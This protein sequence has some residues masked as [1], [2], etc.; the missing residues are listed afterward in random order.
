[1]ENDKKQQ[2]SIEIKPEVANGTY[3][4][5]VI[6]GHSRSEF[7]LDFATRLPAMPKAMV[8]S[9]IVMVPEHC[10]RLLNVLYDNIAKYE[11]Q[12]GPIELGNP[13]PKGATFNLADLAS[14]GTKS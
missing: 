5:L 1:M 11:A 3:S 9:R 8:N 4:N 13:E 6:V 14:N 2:L 12:F 10:K 7:V